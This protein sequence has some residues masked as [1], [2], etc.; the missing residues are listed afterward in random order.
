MQRLGVK[1]LKTNKK[2]DE[3]STSGSTL[4]YDNERNIL[5]EK[6]TSEQQ[7]PID[8][9]DNTEV[10]EQNNRQKNFSN[11]TNNKQS[12]IW[13][14]LEKLPPTEKYKKRV[15]CLVKISGQLCGHIMGSDGST[16]N[17]IFHLAKHRVT[18]DTDLS[19]NNKE[20]VESPLNDSS[21]KN[22]LDNKFI[23]III[24]DDQ[25]LSI[26]SD[27]GFREFDLSENDHYLRLISDVSTRWNSSY[28]AWRR[29][30]KIHD[31]I[32]VMAMT[33]LRD[34]D[35]TTRK[36]GKRLREINLN[37]DEWDAIKQLIKILEPFASGTELLEGSNYATISFMYDAI[38]EITNGIVR[39]NEI[40]PEEID[41]TNHTTIFDYDI[42]IE[43]SDDDVI[44]DH[45]KQRKI[46]VS[47]PQDC[48]NLI[49]KVRSALYTA[50]N[51][52]WNV[53]QDEGMI[54]TF[55]DPR[56]KSLNFAFESQLTRTKSLLR[57]IYVKAK[58]DL[59]ANREHQNSQSPGNPLLRNIFANRYRPERH[60]EIE[61]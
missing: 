28:L 6:D 56:C 40:D 2:R 5:G 11:D 15:K 58:Q 18:R 21:K 60:D 29:L 53:P 23:G 25:P 47:I 24:K 36:D 10:I 3:S 19:Q 50:M 31:Y 38:T 46:S 27:E 52:Y 20:N 54:A 49:E 57:E 12:F 16:G 30:E 13:N 4:I 61:D 8:N 59:G 37:E 17:F 14:Y 44:D 34:D 55:L 7:V 32:D 22:R 51:Y 33:I 41:L 45:P 48:H 39:S 1:V 43:D 42:G 35:P 26:K 9:N